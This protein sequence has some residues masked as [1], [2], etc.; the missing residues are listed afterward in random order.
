MILLIDLPQCLAAVIR[1]L[2]EGVH[3]KDAVDVLGIGNDLPVVHRALIEFISTLP[4]RPLIG[5]TENSTFAIGGF[6]GRIQDVGIGGGDSE[7]DAPH[8]FGGES[9][10]QLVPVRPRVGGFVDRALRAAIDQGED[11]TAAL[12][13]S[14]I[15]DVSIRR[16]HGDIN[17]ARVFADSEHRLPGLAGIGRFIEAAVAAGSPERAF[18][19]HIHH[20]AIAGINH[21][22]SDVL[23]FFQPHILPG[24]AAVFRAVHAVAVS[25][26]ALA[27]A[28]AGAHPYDGGV[29]GIECDPA[30]GV[31]AFPVENRSPGGA[32]IHRL[33]HSARGDAHEV[34]GVILGIHRKRDDPS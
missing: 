30:H 28:L 20:F 6:Y 12:I 27:V 3:H 22:P 17:H 9:R 26:A 32:V 34:L 14:R 23:G 15:K 8:I 2:Q 24:L 11:V 21:N 10:F 31:R 5:R 13:C 19:R 4:V 7:S 16:I 33:P 29:V 1:D 18:C 25:N